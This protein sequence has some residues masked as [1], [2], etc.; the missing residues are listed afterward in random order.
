MYKRRSFSLIFPAYNEESH[1]RKNIN[2]FWETGVFDEIIAGYLEKRG[3][4][5]TISNNEK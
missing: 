2:S 4:I 3:S 5:I 1:I